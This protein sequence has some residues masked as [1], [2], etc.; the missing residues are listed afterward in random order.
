MKPYQLIL[1]MNYLRKEFKMNKRMQE[2]ITDCC[3]HGNYFF[4]KETMEFW[5]SKIEYGMTSDDLFITSE[6]NFDDTKRLYSV[7]EYNWEKHDVKTISFQKFNT[8]KDA[9]EF[10]KEV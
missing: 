10:I 2:A 4:D 1:P 7:R 3:K 9:M 8:L 5:D 6:K